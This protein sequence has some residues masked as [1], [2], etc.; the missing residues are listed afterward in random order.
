MR[1]FKNRT[2]CGRQCLGEQNH[3]STTLVQVSALND[4]DYHSVFIC[5]QIAYISARLHGVMEDTKDDNELNWRTKG[6]YRI[7]TI[8]IRQTY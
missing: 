8:F 3:S 4:Q 5:I 1:F 7:D 6:I 2:E